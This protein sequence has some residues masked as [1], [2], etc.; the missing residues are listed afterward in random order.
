MKQFYILVSI[1]LCIAFACKKEPSS[2]HSN[3][4]IKTYQTDSSATSLHIFQMPDGGFI[5]V[6][7]E[8]TGLA[9]V[10]LMTRIDKYGNFKWNK[11]VSMYYQFNFSAI[12]QV[13]DGSFIGQ[14]LNNMIKFDTL[15]NIKTSFSV[16]RQVNINCQ[17]MTHLGSKII[18]P[19]C[20]T[21]SDTNNVNEIYVYDENLMPVNKDSFYNSRINK[22]IIGLGVKN[23]DTDGTYNIWGSVYP[24]NNL[25]GFNN[26]KLFA[27]KIPKTGKATTTIVDPT[28]HNFGDLEVMQTNAIDSEGILLGTRYSATISFPIVIKFDKILNIAWENSFAVNTASIM[29]NYIN[30]C[31]DGGFIIAGSIQTTGTTYSQPYALKIDANGKKVW[32]KTITSPSLQGNG[33]FYSVIELSDGSLAFVG[34][35]S[36]YGKGRAGNQILFV[37]TD[38]NGNL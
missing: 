5:I 7:I 18:V 23:I 11:T 21:Y 12:T 14:Q 32:S 28:V 3:T 25:S 38:A 4:F 27:A 16:P 33:I 13:A 35:S 37:K 1:V 22:K 36:Q 34:G 26:P 20:D 6:S 2:E 24:I 8:G 29:P 15:G 19:A 31:K 30:S 10:P 9:G 17:P